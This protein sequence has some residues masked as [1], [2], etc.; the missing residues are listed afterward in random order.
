[1]NLFT[2]MWFSSHFLIKKIRKKKSSVIKKGA[3]RLPSQLFV[4]NARNLRTAFTIRFWKSS[5]SILKSSGL[6]LGSGFSKGLSAQLSSAQVFKNRLSSAERADWAD[7][8]WLSNKWRSFFPNR[9]LLAKAHLQSRIWLAH[10]R[11]SSGKLLAFRRY[12]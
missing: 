10:F 9:L 3:W 1:M 6:R 8:R 2:N 7:S 4:R 12:F 5:A 11:S